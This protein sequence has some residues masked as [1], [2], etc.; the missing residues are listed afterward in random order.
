[1]SCRLL[2][3]LGFFPRDSDHIPPP[4]PG[5]VTAA[6]IPSC[7]QT[8]LHC[9]APSGS[10]PITGH[11]V[12]S[13]SARADSEYRWPTWLRPTRIRSPVTSLLGS[14]HRIPAEYTARADL[15]PSVQSRHMT[16][17]TATPPGSGN[18]PP[19][20]VHAPAG[21]AQSSKSPKLRTQ[22]ATEGVRHGYYDKAYV[23]A[24]VKLYVQRTLERSCTGRE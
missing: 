18:I 24:R 13:R 21:Q 15:D 14:G 4:L 10:G 7:G 22:Q 8:A 20:R 19:A 3:S 9:P 6:L 16:L 5:T 1:M 23:G 12:T 2:T 17:T 11:H